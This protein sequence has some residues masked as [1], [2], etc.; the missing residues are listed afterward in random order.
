MKYFIPLLSL[1]TFSTTVSLADIRISGRVLDNKEK[2]VAGANVYLYNTIDGGTTDSAGNFSFTTTESGAQSLVATDIRHETTGLPLTLSKDT[3]GIIL[4]MKENKS[5]DL[6]AVVITA[7]AFEASSDKA[8]T[9]LKPLDIVTTAGANADPIKAIQ[10]LPGTQQVGT[11]NGMF[12]RGG[13]ASEGAV[14]LDGMVVQNA[15]FNSAPGVSTRS[16][17]SAFTFKD[18]SFSS[19]GYSAKYSQALSGV[20]EMNT[21]DLADKSNVNLGASV[22]GIYA[23]FTKRFK[24]SS[25][26]FGGNYS[27]LTPFYWFTTT[28]FK[29]YSVPISGSGNVRYAWKP[30]KDGMFKASFNANYSSNGVAIPNP[31]AGVTDTSANAQYNPFLGQADTLN[32]RTEDMYYYGT[33]YYKQMFKNKYS[34]FTAAS[35]SYDNTKNKMGTYPMGEDQYRAQWR[36][37]GKKYINSRLT[38][39]LGAETQNYGVDRNFGGYHQKFDEHLLAGYT[40]ASWTPVYWLAVKPGIR[41]ERSALLNVD[42]V[43]PRLAMAIRTGDYSQISLAGGVFYQ[44]PGNLYLLV[45]KRPDMQQ[46]IHYISNWQWSKQDRTL[47]LEAYYKNYQDLVRE[48][49]APGSTFVSNRFRNISSSVQVDNSGYGYAQGLELFW[50]DKKTVK[51]LDY[52]V[53]YSYINTKRFYENFPY[54]TNPYSQISGTPTFIADHNLSLV[55]K[56]F[57]EKWHTNFSATYSFSSGFH[58][59]NP[60]V[61]LS[62]S[63]FLNDHTPATN[64]I[65]LTV[66]YLKSFGK[67]FS[68]FYISVDNVF[69]IK[70]IY[71]YR[72]QF[73]ANNQVIPGS[74]TSIVPALYRTVFFGVNCSLTQFKKDE[75]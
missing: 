48:L 17:F 34:L 53:T 44:N 31:Y 60:E 21:N 26:D 51:N 20:L 7:G 54:T 10:M 42:K 15:F 39:L 24:N 38:M 74:R 23:S 33:L 65:A 29:F 63:T 30:N 70:N 46:A 18:V 50:R 43:G 3:S 1:L 62:Q 69:N 47:R 68:V 8:K 5:R 45:G 41:Y 61:P 66:A 37:E 25:L 59:Y 16:R 22:G 19:G 35:F 4:H 75:L 72:Y 56:Y 28:N 32:F 64:N 12:I 49:Y 57:V 52:W 40:E 9:I 58:Y 71:G 13:D 67:W 27:N 2:P 36:V 14:V 6:D 73:D 55:G 11:E